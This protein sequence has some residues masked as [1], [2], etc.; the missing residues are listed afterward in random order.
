MKQSKRLLI[1]TM[2]ALYA[3][4]ALNTAISRVFINED[5]SDPLAQQFGSQEQLDALRDFTALR[6]EGNF[7]VEVVRHDGY[8]SAWKIGQD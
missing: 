4:V 2:L 7:G 1:G 6:I 3:V 5:A 8:S